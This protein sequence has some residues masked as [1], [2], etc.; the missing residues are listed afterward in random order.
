M[1]Q[2]FITF[3]ALLCLLVIGGSAGAQ[4]TTTPPLPVD[5]LCDAG[6]AWDDGRCAIPGHEGASALAWE[7]GY[8]MA[9]VLDGRISASQVPAQCQHLVRT[10]SEICRALTEDDFTEEGFFAC[11]RSN[12]TGSV[13]IDPSFFPEE[14]FPPGF[15]ASQAFIEIR[16]V[17]NEPL[18]EEDCPVVSGYV[19]INVFPAGFFEVFTEAERAS[20][21]LG[22]WMCFYVDPDFFGDPRD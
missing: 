12:R 20:L 16:F 11:I 9:R 18:D 4:N 19:L 8:Y 14:D 15:D 17:A 3:V 7:C 21:G 5:N 1:I 6:Q 13:Y 2:K 22:G 10:L